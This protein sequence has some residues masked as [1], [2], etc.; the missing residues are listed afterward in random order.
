MGCLDKNNN[1]P[2]KVFLRHFYNR[3]LKDF[4]FHIC[5]TSRE[6]SLNV[7]DANNPVS[8]KKIHTLYKF[9]SAFDSNKI[10]MAGNIAFV[11]PSGGMEKKNL[12]W[13]FR[14]SQEMLIIKTYDLAWRI[15][16]SNP[17]LYV[18]RKG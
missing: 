16:I 15:Q 9:M 18:R 13:Y 10:N 8:Q 17:L 2:R 14:S 7:T 1:M 4:Y 12:S 5:L 11:Q 6:H 3:H